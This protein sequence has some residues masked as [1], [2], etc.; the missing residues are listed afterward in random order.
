[1]QHIT[2]WQVI[3]HNNKYKQ[4]N[5]KMNKETL[6]ILLGILLL[7]S[8]QCIAQKRLPTE[9]LILLDGSVLE[10]KS[11]QNKIVIINLWG[12]WCKPCVAEIPELNKLEKEFT[13]NEQVIFLALA[14]DASKK[15]NHFLTQ[16]EFRFIHLDNSNAKYFDK[17]FIKSYP[18]TFVYNKKGIL[19]KKYSGQLDNENLNELKKLI[20]NKTTYNN[21]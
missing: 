19:I 20:K 11:V 3:I 1:M 21:K 5:H 13:T 18:R 15:L 17:G 4:K 16:K 9:D 7:F 12:T 2:R 8:N 6:I 14:T 10:N